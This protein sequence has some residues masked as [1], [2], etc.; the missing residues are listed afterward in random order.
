MG[1]IIWANTHRPHRQGSRTMLRNCFS[2]LEKKK[3]HNQS[4]QSSLKPE[5]DVNQFLKT[6][7]SNRWVVYSERP[8]RAGPPQS[9]PPDCR[10]WWDT[11][12]AEQPLKQRG[13]HCHAK[14]NTLQMWW[15][16]WLNDKRGLGKFQ[17][18]TT[19]AY[20]RGGR[21]QGQDGGKV[22]WLGTEKAGLGPK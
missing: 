17:N 13:P 8:S 12:R 7:A 3:K 5:T 20:R 19:Q 4:K 2:M 6:Q 1:I 18:M 22:G 15:E 11:P 9:W 21:G 14:H 10:S 16:T